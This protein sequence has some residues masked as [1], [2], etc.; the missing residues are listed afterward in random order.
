MVRNVNSEH[1]KAR[2]NCFKLTVIS[3]SL[4]CPR[5]AAPILRLPI[6]EVVTFVSAFPLNTTSSTMIQ[7]KPHLL[8][9]VVLPPRLT[10]RHT[11]GIFFLP[12]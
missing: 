3:L 1:F 7:E 6:K 10:M 5:S 9:L 8:L 12:Q 11:V 2:N 4:I